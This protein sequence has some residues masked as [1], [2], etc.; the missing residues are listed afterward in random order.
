MTRKLPRIDSAHRWPDAI[1]QQTGV[2]VLCELHTRRGSNKAV[3]EH[4]LFSTSDG[5]SSARF[6]RRG[7]WGIIATHYELTCAF[8]P[9]I[10]ELWTYLIFL[11]GSHRL[12]LILVI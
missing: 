5:I 4:I 11:G 6:W 12:L 8:R 10:Q 2:D 7:E 3:S 1:V 9:L